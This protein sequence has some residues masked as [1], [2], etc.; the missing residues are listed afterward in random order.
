M[1]NQL[2]LKHKYRKTISEFLVIKNEGDLPIYNDRLR[3][4]K[5]QLMKIPYHNN[6]TNDLRF[7]PEPPKKPPI[8]VQVEAYY[9]RIKTW[10]HYFFGDRDVTKPAPEIFVKPSCVAYYEPHTIGRFD[11]VYVYRQPLGYQFQDIMVIG[12]LEFQ[13]Q[14]IFVKNDLLRPKQYLALITKNGINPVSN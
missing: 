3:K 7:L 4:L 9:Q 14:G 8:L 5:V 11:K 2:Q 12:E 1:I 13:L 6:F 10:Y